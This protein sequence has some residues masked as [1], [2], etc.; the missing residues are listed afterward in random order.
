MKDRISDLVGQM[1][2]VQSGEP[3]I[4]SNFNKKMKSISEDNFF[5]RPMEHMHSVAEI[6]SHLTTWRNET[7]LKMKA[8]KGSLTDDHPSNWKDPEEL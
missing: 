6:I 7:L 2:E 3:W 8:G 4:G 5:R 1:T